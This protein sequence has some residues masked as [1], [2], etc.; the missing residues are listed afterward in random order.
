MCNTHFR[1]NFSSVDSSV[2]T[3]T[4]IA[5]VTVNGGADRSSLTTF[6]PFHPF[7]N[8]PPLHSG[9][10]IQ[11]CRSS[12]NLTSSGHQNRLKI[13]IILWHLV[14]EAAILKLLIAVDNDDQMRA[15]SQFLLFISALYLDASNTTFDEIKFPTTFLLFLLMSDYTGL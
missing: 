4:L 3:D 11:N 2:V 13:V 12:A 8:F 5:H 10:V 1:H 9:I 6:L 15:G 14:N 7:V